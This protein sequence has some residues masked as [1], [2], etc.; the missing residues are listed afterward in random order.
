MSFQTSPGSRPSDVLHYERILANCKHSF[1]V[2]CIDKWFDCHSTCPV[3]RA[4]AEPRL[5]PE[6]R[7][8]FV[9]RMSPS[10]PPMESGN[11]CITVNLETTSSSG[12]GTSSR[13]S[14]FKRIILSR[15]RSSQR[16]QAQSCSRE[17]HIGDLESDRSRI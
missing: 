1:H 5:L 13:L 11:L 4:E 8:G 16:L 15:E 14:S 17:D 9:G 6:P 3:C 12:N 2:G 10:T 7:E